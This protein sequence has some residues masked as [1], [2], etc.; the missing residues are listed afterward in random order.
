MVRGKVPSSSKRVQSKMTKFAS[1]Q[2]KPLPPARSR[3]RLS[4]L[5]IYV[6]F[7]TG[8]T[9]ILT[10][11]LSASN[12]IRIISNAV[13]ANPGAY[14]F[15]V[16]SVCYGCLALALRSFYFE[17]S[18]PKGISVLR[19][20]HP[21]VIS[22]GEYGMASIS[23][24]QIL[25]FTLIVAY[26]SIKQVFANRGLPVLD[27]SI[28]GLLGVSAAG[29]IGSTIICS[30]RLRLS[31]DNWNWLI[32]N[33]FL[34]EGKTIDPRETADLKDIVVTDGVFDPTRFQLLLSSAIVGFS[35]LRGDPLA[36]S[37]MGD[38]SNLIT[39]SNA[40][41]IGG[42]ALSPNGV[43]ELDDRVT[44]IRTS[45]PFPVSLHPLMDEDD[46][47]IRRSLVS[48][49]GQNAVKE[50]TLSKQQDCPQVCPPPPSS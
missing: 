33:D 1:W 48:A 34:R 8:L 36:A 18:G 32:A 21:A 10:P 46:L 3:R 23:S 28:L 17:T 6:A 4:E 5:A 19:W 50:R 26:I 35:M 47:F 7:I 15:L 27:S 29:K 24:L 16:V 20:L 22:A 2:R 40:V 39:G 30:S 25:W 44:L 45:H 43:K 13:L 49:Y 42:K 31:L 9:I 12:P 41:Y 37:T 38:W 11:S 14:A